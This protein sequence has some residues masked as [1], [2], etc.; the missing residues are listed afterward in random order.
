MFKDAL[1]FNQPLNHFEFGPNVCMTCG[2]DEM[3]Q[4]AVRFDVLL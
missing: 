3:F 4:G 2:I 1:A